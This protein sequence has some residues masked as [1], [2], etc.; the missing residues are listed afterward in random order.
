MSHLFDRYAKAVVRELEMIAPESA[1]HRLDTVF[2]G[3]G[4]PSLFSIDQLSEILNGCRIFFD[5]ADDAEISLEMNPKTASIQ[6]FLD[7]KELGINRLS[8]GIQS[9]S[10]RELQILGRIHTAQEAFDT[11]GFAKKTG[12]SNINIDLI[13]GV[14][15]QT[16]NHWQWNLQTAIDLEPT[17]LALYQLSVEDKSQMDRLIKS[18]VLALPEE[19]EILAMDAVT[20]S[21]CAF[22]EFQ[23]YELSNY[24]Q[25]GFA[26]RHNINYWKNREYIGVGAAAVSFLQGKRMK[27][28][29]HPEKYCA[30]IESSKNAVVESEILDREASFRET[31]VMGLRMVNG[32]SLDDLRNRYGIDVRSYYGK[33][34]ERLLAMKLVEVD[35]FRMR[36]TEKGRMVANQVMAD[37]V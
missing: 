6:K 36:L 37:L 12:Y 17:H 3:G 20:A 26:C 34:L 23:Q 25:K 21:H 33:I 28:I 9:F 29:A 19:D 24:C 31:V 32:V 13:S 18:R 16:A 5:L 4:T 10:D 2:F 27:N 7:W 11:V 15:G 14:P 22:A 35:D 30:L 1:F 8:I